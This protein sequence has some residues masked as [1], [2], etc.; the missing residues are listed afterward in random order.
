M[1]IKEANGRVEDKVI[2]IVAEIANV[3]SDQLTRESAFFTDIPIDSLAMIE[4]LMKL[5]EEYSMDIPDEDTDGILT[6]GDAADYISE[7]M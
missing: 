2:E 7:H 5:E 6:V 1:Q 4:I 3:D